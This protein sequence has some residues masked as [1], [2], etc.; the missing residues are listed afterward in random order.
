VHLGQIPVISPELPVC[1]SSVAQQ[2]ASGW[3][4][5]IMAFDYVS[6]CMLDSSMLPLKKKSNRP[7]NQRE[8]YIFLFAEPLKH[9]D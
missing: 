1:Y 3:T 2:A 4:A 7:Q 5:H 8:S 9:Q 6:C